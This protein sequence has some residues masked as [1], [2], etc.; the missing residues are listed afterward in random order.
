MGKLPTEVQ[1]Q[2]LTEI[3]DLEGAGTDAAARPAPAVLNGVIESAAA[4][5]GEI[6]VRPAGPAELAA[7]RAL[8]RRGGVGFPAELISDQP[9]QASVEAL[10]RLKVASPRAAEMRGIPRQGWWTET[11]ALDKAVRM[12]VNGAHWT[13]I[14]RALGISGESARRGVVN[15]GDVDPALT[16]RT[17]RR[18]WTPEELATAVALRAEGRRWSDIAVLIGR[19]SGKAVWQAIRAER[20]AA[21]LTE[22]LRSRARSGR[23][24]Q[25]PPGL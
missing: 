11:D 5:F 10:N 8:F 7:A 24:S 6:E 1:D 14:G 16:R 4:R 3:S 20:H 23:D 17:P 21:E 22:D 13:E 19:S 2:L 25:K 9:L 12:R 15:Y 18:L